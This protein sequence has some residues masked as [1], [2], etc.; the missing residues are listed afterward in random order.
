MKVNQLSIEQCFDIAKIV[1]DNLIKDVS[2]INQITSGQ[3]NNRIEIF[4]NDS[5]FKI[6]IIDIEEISFSERNHIDSH[7]HLLPIYNY[8]QLL[9]YLLNINAI[10]L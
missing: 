5:I 4:W 10:S 7:Y 9:R 2:E 1:S 6:D 8:L 3:V